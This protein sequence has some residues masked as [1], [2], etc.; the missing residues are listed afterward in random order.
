V[1]GQLG[2]QRHQ[3]AVGD[4]QSMDQDRRESAAGLA[5]EQRA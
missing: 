5:S 2:G 4:R 3:L 1:A